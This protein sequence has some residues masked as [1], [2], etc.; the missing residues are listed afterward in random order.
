MT[1]VDWIAVAVIAIAALVGLRRGLIGG[2]LGL[3]GIAVGAYIGAKLAP[4][5]LLR[6]RVAVHAAR[7]ARRG[8]GRS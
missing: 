1:T 6:Q 3:A 5:L 8:G 4:E 7:R 2:L